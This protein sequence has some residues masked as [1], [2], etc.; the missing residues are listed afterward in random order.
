MTKDFLKRETTKVV[1]AY[2]SQNPISMTELRVLIRITYD[3][4]S[5]IMSAPDE[6]R[7][8]A[9]PKTKSQIA[10]SRKNEWL[11]SFIDGQP[12][13]SLKRHLTSHGFTPESYRTR[14]ALPN[15]YPM[16][17]PAYAA[18]RSQIARHNYLKRKAL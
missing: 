13:K 12:Y 8:R 14:Y 6:E 17:A 1:I 15:D 5:L 16:T 9:E 2:V 7:L 10:A 4:L 18:Q 3:A 11:I